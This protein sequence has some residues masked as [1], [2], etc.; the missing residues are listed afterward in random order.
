MLLMVE[1]GTRGRICNSIHQCAKANK[2]MNDYD[3]NKES[4]C[5]NYWDVN[6]LYG[7]AM[8]QKLL[9][10]NFEWGEDTSQFNVVFIENYD[11]KS[12]L[13]YILEVDGSI[14]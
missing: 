9:T 4:S 10:F 12:N 5:I 1:R 13:G 14:P 11:E 3:E 6:N 7:W 8:M 2:Y